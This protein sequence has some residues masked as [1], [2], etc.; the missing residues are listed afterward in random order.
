MSGETLKFD[1]KTKKLKQVN[2]DIIL[3]G[4]GLN[5]SPE[6][7]RETFDKT[8]QE[9]LIGTRPIGVFLSGGLDSTMISYHAN[10]YLKQNTFTNHIAMPSR[11]K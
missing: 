5:F 8:I 2:R 10:K 3:G 9:S 1:V 6:E 11:S 7:F 4:K